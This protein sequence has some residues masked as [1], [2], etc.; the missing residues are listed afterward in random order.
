MFFIGENDRGTF[1]DFRPELHDSDGLMIRSG[2]GEW[3]WRPLRN[4]SIAKT[5]A[6]VDRNVKGYG[7]LQRDRHFDH[8]EDIDL[9]YQLRPSYWVEPKTDFGDGHVELFEMPTTDET[10]DNIVTS[11]VAKDGYTVGK[12][13]SYA[14]TLTAA[15][16]LDRLSSNVK[17]L[18]TFQT[19][20]RILGSNEPNLPNVRRFIV[21]FNGGGLNY[22]KDDPGAVKVIA[23]TSKGKI[24]RAYTQYN[25]YIEGFRATFDVELAPGETADLRAFLKAG[26]KA[27]SETWIFP[28]EAPAAPQ[29]K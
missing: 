14:Y 18:S 5:S 17:V 15:L 25:P 6:F 11:W 8:Y 22:Y 7:L 1:Q 24:V 16:D 29:K 20:A 19:E 3:I 23:T 13:F 4:P 10:N 2:N 9:A 26:I 12:P 28:W 27:L 21:D